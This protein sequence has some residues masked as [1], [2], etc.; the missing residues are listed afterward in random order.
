V[1]SGN[2][3]CVGQA[4]AAAEAVGVDSEGINSV[5]ALVEA[6]AVLIQ[7]SQAVPA[8]PL[9]QQTFPA[10][11]GFAA[12]QKAQ[13]QQAAAASAASL[14]FSAVP[15]SLLVKPLPS[16][17]DS[18]A[19]YGKCPANGCQLQRIAKM[20]S[21]GKGANGGRYFLTCRLSTLGN[22]HNKAFVWRDEWLEKV[23]LPLKPGD[24]AWKQRQASIANQ[25]AAGKRPM[26]LDEPLSHSAPL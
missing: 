23:N 5:A 1:F 4:A 24:I 10:Y 19:A 22:P 11:D 17:I 7:Q 3:I 16:G 18:E 15:V 14:R 20:T 6:P 13:Q 12:Q 8:V 21:A 26:E 25:L 2:G 9:S